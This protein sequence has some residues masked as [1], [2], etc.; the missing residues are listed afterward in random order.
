MLVVIVYTHGFI[1]LSILI[2][3]VASCPGWGLNSGP[4]YYRRGQP[5]APRLIVLERRHGMAKILKSFI[6]NPAGRPGKA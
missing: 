6:I 2:F 5:G 4:C 1:Y 3:K